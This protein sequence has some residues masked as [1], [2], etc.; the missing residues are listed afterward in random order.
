MHA[1]TMRQVPL[2]GDMCRSSGIRAAS[3]LNRGIPITQVRRSGVTLTS[4]QMSRIRVAII[5]AVSAALTFANASAQA[6]VPLSK[7]AV[8]A[9]V[10]SMVQA[11]MVAKG[12]ASMSVVI[13][14]GGETLVE[15]AWG[16]ADVASKRP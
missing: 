15:R 9:R 7:A 13:R 10:D 16:L 12:P 1:A 11:Y 8:V 2:V 14:R 6:P 5:A 3:R 4:P